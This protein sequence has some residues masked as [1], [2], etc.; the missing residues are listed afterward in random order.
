MSFSFQAFLPR[1]MAVSTAERIRAALGGAVGIAITAFI[2]LA[3]AQGLGLSPW[4][5][6]PLGASAVLVFAVPS[7]PLAQPWSVVGGNTVSALVGLLMCNL[8]PDPVIAASLAVGGAIGAMFA[9]RCL[10]PPGG[11]MALLVVLTHTQAWIFALFPAC[12]NSLLLVAVGVAYNSLTKKAYPHI[13]ATAPA[14]TPSGLMRISE[15]DLAYALAEENETQVIAPDTLS[16]IIERTEV[17]A[18]QRMAGTR[19]CADVMTSPVHT[20]HFGTHLKDVWAVFQSHDIKAVPVIDRK[21]RIHGIITPA[22]IEA[23]AGKHGGLKDLLA[24]KGTAHSEM[25]EV[26]VQIMSEDYVTARTDD[27][28]EGLMPLFSKGDRRHVLVMDDDRKLVG[29]ISTSDLMRAVF[30]AA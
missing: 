26:A 10:H 6:A 24:H 17:R 16:R 19:T 9:L 1:P 7:S 25:P 21:H 30:H 22:M 3:I 28:L 12:A 5:V 14:A 13:M 29:I 23:E 20:A 18:W 15:A 27:S 4:L 11:A 2:S 8:I